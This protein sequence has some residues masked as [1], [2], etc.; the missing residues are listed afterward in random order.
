MRKLIEFLRGNVKVSDDDKR[1]LGIYI[2][3][4]D[5]HAIPATT[6]SPAIRVDLEHIRRITGFLFVDGEQTKGKP[7]GVSSVQLA[8]AIIE[9]DDREPVTIN[10]LMHEN[11]D[12]YSKTSFMLEFDDEDR[13]KRVYMAARYVMR[14]TSSGYGPWSEICFAIIP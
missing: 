10:R 3:P 5:T 4:H 13:G 1:L 8:H 11:L 9:D 6:K 14:A 7:D 12:L 2:A